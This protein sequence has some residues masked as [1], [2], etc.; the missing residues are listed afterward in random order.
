MQVA[1]AGKAAA[2]PGGARRCSPSDRP[3][4]CRGRKAPPGGRSRI[5]AEEEAR[6]KREAEESEL[7]RGRGGRPQEVEAEA[8][9]QVKEKARQDAEAANGARLEADASGRPMPRHGARPKRRS[10]GRWATRRNSAMRPRRRGGGSPKLSG[11][12]RRRARRA[13]ERDDDLPG[14]DLAPLRKIQARHCRNPGLLKPLSIDE[15]FKSFA[16]P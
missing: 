15:F 3:R 7:R 10:G 11:L 13:A 5:R 2:A 8:E 4:S 1:T 14:V 16:N 9:L 12:P 6:L